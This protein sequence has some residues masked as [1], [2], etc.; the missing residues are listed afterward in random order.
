MEWV[1]QPPL[2]VVCTAW[3]PK[4]WPLADNPNSTETN[5][6]QRETKP[7]RGKNPKS[8]TLSSCVLPPAYHLAWRVSAD[9]TFLKPLTANL[10]HFDALLS[11]RRMWREN[12]GDKGSGVAT[13][14]ETCHIFE[15]ENQK[16]KKKDERDKWGSEHKKHK[17]TDLWFGSFL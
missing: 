3:P 2:W 12:A 16:K 11:H 5:I 15:G 13:V 10:S 1:S 7:D 6:S 4:R 17:L 14:A 8:L 9:V